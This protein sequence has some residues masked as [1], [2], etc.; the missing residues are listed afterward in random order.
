MRVLLSSFRLLVLWCLSAALISGCGGSSGDSVSVATPSTTVLVYIEGTNLEDGLAPPDDSGALNGRTALATKNIKEMLAAASSDNLR[1]VITTGA[2]NK[3]DISGSGELVDDWTTVKRFVIKNHQLVPQGSQ[4]V[5]DM[6]DPQ[7]LTDFIKWGQDNFA[8]DR[9]VLVLWDHGGGAL[10]DFGGYGTG[11]VPKPDY[12][13]SKMTFS[14][15]RKA[16][17]DAVG[18]D[19]AR[20][21]EVIGFDAC[22]M[23]T[24]EIAE[25][26]KDVGRYL[27]A[28]QDIEPGGGWDYTSFLNFIV[29]NPSADGAAIGKAIAEGYLAKVKASDAKSNSHEADSLTFST[30]KLAAIPRVRAAL[31][32]FSNK[33]RNLLESGA[34][35]SRLATWQNIAQSRSWAPDFFASN[36]DIA[37]TT[38][39]VDLTSLIEARG[40]FESAE[41]TELVAAI[42]SAVVYKLENIKYRNNVGGLN[43]MFPSIA[44]WAVDTLLP[45]YDGFA[46]VTDE[47]RAL[48]KS[49]SAYARSMQ[50]LVFATVAED[51]AAKTISVAFTT[52]NPKY[53]QVYVAIH[54]TFANY[55]YGHQPVWNTVGDPV[56]N[57]F[58]YT[59]D[60]KWFTL[61]GKFA[62]VIAAPTTEMGLQVLK[63]PMMRVPKGKGIEYGRNGMYWLRYNF[64][65][66]SQ[67]P[68]CIGFLENNEG[69]QVSSPSSFE[70]G[71]VIYLK[72]WQSSMEKGKEA[73][74]AWVVDQDN[75]D[76]KFTVPDVPPGA[77]YFPTF[78]R[79]AISGKPYAFFAFDLRWKPV[80]S[81]DK[82]IE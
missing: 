43:V 70:G 15:I 78:A 26:L 27:A 34:D 16:I 30:T 74:G 60:G 72:A 54:Q 69:N 58:H 23:G 29:S 82:S 66:P 47:Y 53:E 37:S 1:V 21:F 33:L 40:D 10:A 32:A 24:L 50:D 48:V 35:S 36:I 38:D 8:A 13:A 46:F 39:A 68:E 67:A 81:E 64:A 52:A 19:Q 77:E 76:L 41:Q 17:S 44:V 14:D 73:T 6:G 71:D 7:T 18:D 31:A 57:G 61:D 9:Y 45:K 55:Y 22:L 51:S 28:S 4:G 65:D 75:D 56:G 3:K 62:S 79:T 2:A 25:A 12:F 80:L 42:K 63:I 49:F 59:A 5:K 20:R 11:L